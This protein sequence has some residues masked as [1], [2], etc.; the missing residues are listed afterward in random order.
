M[1]KMYGS[2]EQLYAALEA[3]DDMVE[4]INPVDGSGDDRVEGYEPRK[5]SS[6]IEKL[7]GAEGIDAKQAD[8]DG[9]A[10]VS[11]EPIE[12]DVTAFR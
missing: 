7:M 9:G 1:D 4:G 11:D 3:N 10:E 12:I 2:L 8:E 6:P 5:S